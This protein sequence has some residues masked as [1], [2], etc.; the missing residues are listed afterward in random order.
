M[1]WRKTPHL[2]QCS[3]A[4]PSC[5]GKCDHAEPHVPFYTDHLSCSR[6]HTCPSPMPRP[7][8][9]WGNAPVPKCRCRRVT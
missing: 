6:W 2:W 3:A 4:S 9:D 7:A 8:Q 1:A 5:A